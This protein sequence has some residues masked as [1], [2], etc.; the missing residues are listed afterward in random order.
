M[1]RSTAGIICWTACFSSAS[2]CTSRARLS[3][4]PVPPVRAATTNVHA[5]PP[6]LT[7]AT[8]SPCRQRTRPHER[9]RAPSR[10][11]LDA[12]APRGGDGRVPNACRRG[13]EEVG[14]GERRFGEVVPLRSDPP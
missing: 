9:Y 3:H 5:S 13:C 8:R 2:F 11:F 1:A 10:L 12:Q 6:R 4:P 14:G 7:P